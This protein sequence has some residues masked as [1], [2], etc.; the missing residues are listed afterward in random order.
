MANPE[1]IENLDGFD[2]LSVR[3]YR[4]GLTVAAAAIFSLALLYARGVTSG[5]AWW[6]ID[7]ALVVCLVNLHLYDKRV[8]WLVRVLVYGGLLLQL[9]EKPAVLEWVGRGGVLMGLSALALKEQFCF[10]IPGL[11]FV[12]LCLALGVIAAWLGQP[13]VAATGFLLAGIWLTLLAA[14]KWRMPLHFDIGD[15]SRYQV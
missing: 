8:R 3:L 6:V 1:V 14:S 4:S 15:K 9:V 7:A 11:K 13:I 10:R 2:R 12:P 5:F